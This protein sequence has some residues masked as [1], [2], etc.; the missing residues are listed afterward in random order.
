[1]IDSTMNKKHKIFQKSILLLI[2]KYCLYYFFLKYTFNYKIK[3]HLFNFH[4]IWDR[5]RNLKWSEYILLIVTIYIHIYA[6]EK[7]EENCRN[8]LFIINCKTNLSI[9]KR[10]QNIYKAAI[11]LFIKIFFLK[12]N[13]YAPLYTCQYKNEVF[14]KNL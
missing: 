3:L 2:R 7:D 11:V 8:I 4:I 6:Y 14:Y 5:L 10:N 9:G 13:E 1:M 12:P